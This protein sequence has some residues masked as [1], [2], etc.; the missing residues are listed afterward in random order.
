MVGQ[1]MTAEQISKAIVK[2]QKKRASVIAPT[3][4]ARS[5]LAEFLCDEE[6]LK[7]PFRNEALCEKAR[8]FLGVEAG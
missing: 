4:E 8:K 5:L 1:G 3:D 6:T 2:R 7:E